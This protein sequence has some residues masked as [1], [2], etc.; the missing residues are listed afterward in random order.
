MSNPNLN[1]QYDAEHGSIPKTAT[2]ARLA[3]DGVWALTVIE[4]P[5]CGSEHRHGGGNGDEPVFGPRVAHCI[6]GRGTYELVP[7]THEVSTTPD[8]GMA[9]WYNRSSFAKVLGM[10]LAKFDRERSKGHIPTPCSIFNNT[11]RWRGATVAQ[12][13][14]ERGAK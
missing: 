7:E 13:L 12:V 9:P 11:A 1:K 4:C 5:F 6:N 14:T 2:R 8:D 3:S 10:P